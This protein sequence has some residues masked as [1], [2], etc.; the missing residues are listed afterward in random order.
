MSKPIE[1]FPKKEVI[2]IDPNIFIHKNPYTKEF[3]LWLKVGVQYFSIG[4]P[5]ETEEH[6]RWHAKMLKKALDKMVLDRKPK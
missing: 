2:K 1:Q 6:A 5:L 3:H 4:M